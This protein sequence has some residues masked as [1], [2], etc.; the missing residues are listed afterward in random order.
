MGEQLTL[1][2][3]AGSPL[4]GWDEVTVDLAR[5]AVVGHPWEVFNPRTAQVSHVQA[6]ISRV[7]SD[8]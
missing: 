2:L 4:T 3:Q 8:A 5:Y 6:T 1:F 7:G